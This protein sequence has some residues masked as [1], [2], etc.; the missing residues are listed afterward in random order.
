MGFLS[1]LGKA[2]KLAAKGTA[3]IA[4]GMSE[5]VT[6]VSLYDEISSKVD[7]EEIINRYY[8]FL[9]NNRDAAIE[10]WGE[11]IYNREL[12]HHPNKHWEK[13]MNQVSY[14]TLDGFENNKYGKE[15]IKHSSPEKQRE[16]Q[17]L[18]KKYDATS[19]NKLRSLSRLHL[20]YIQAQQ[21]APTSLKKDAYWELERRKG[22][23]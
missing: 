3:Y 22:N 17:H 4:S 20:E 13:S 2:A 6:G 23:V 1:G 11:D 19:K 14:D 10:A 7:E 12:K 21:D 8:E 9:E 15:V 5:E 16:Y 18:K